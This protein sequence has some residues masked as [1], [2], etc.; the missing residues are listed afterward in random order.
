MPLRL[1]R[2]NRPLPI[3]IA[4]ALVIITVKAHDKHID[5]NFASPPFFLAL[6]FLSLNYFPHSNFFFH[7]FSEPQLRIPYPNSAAQ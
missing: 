3:K 5:E 4:T 6:K 2:K 1:R 7:H